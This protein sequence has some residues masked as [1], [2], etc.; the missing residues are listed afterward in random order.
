MPLVSSQTTFCIVK[1]WKGNAIVKWQTWGALCKSPSLYDETRVHLWDAW[2]ICLGGVCKWDE[3]QKTL[4]WCSFTAA[5][6]RVMVQMKINVMLLFGIIAICPFVW[7]LNSGLNKQFFLPLPKYK[8]YAFYSSP[9][10]LIALYLP[11]QWILC[12]IPLY[13]YI[14]TH[15]PNQVPASD[16]S[17][18]DT[19]PKL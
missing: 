10:I 13:C 3:S 4:P 15:F 16:F 11:L 14:A 18:S 7:N 19:L 2:M 12:L 9:F 17:L 8:R 6:F 5:G 1:E